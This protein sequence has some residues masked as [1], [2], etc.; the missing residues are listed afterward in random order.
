MASIGEMNRLVGKDGNPVDAMSDDSQSTGGQ[1]CLEPRS[2]EPRPGTLPLP[3][4]SH[5]LPGPWEPRLLELL[6]ALSF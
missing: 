1:S 4:T 2:S 3:H 5:Q 6:S